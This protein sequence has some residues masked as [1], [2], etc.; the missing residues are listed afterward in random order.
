MTS[1]LQYPTPS[2]TSTPATPAMF[3]YEHW[4]DRL[5]RLLKSARLCPILPG[6]APPYMSC[7]GT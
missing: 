1:R 6:E 3:S 4:Q 2:W 7:S 5:N